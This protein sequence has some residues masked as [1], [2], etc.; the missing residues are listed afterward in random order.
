MSILPISSF[1]LVPAR[2]GDLPRNRRYTEEVATAGSRLGVNST[3]LRL[4]K[5]DKTFEPLRE[6]SFRAANSQ[7]FMV[8]LITPPRD[9]RIKSPISF[10]EGD[11]VA[12][13]IAGLEWL[14]SSP[15]FEA[16]CIAE[17]GWPAKLVVPDPRAFAIHKKWLSTRVD[18]EPIKKPRDA[19]QSRLVKDIVNEY[20][21]H[22]PFEDA[23]VMAF[24]EDLRKP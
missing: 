6:N 3:K 15:R 5:V 24:P 4:R 9:M 23:A 7:E 13:E 2:T 14:M 18:R 11:L 1:Y 19:D 10:A 12:T 8:D 22:L 20:F 17:D 21:P 16:V